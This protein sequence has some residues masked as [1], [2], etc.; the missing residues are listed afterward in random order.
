[1][2]IYVRLA[3]VPS[4]DAFLKVFR[5][6]GLLWETPACGGRAMYAV[7]QEGRALPEEG[8]MCP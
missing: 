6:G 4:W 5:G 7:A 8:P 3:W 2:K 1:M